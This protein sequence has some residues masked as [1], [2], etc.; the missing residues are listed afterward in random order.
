MKDGEGLE[1]E[2]QHNVIEPESNFTICGLLI[3][4]L[5]I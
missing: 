1:N 5:E 2:Y 3:K 4:K